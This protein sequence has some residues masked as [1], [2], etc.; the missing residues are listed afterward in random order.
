MKTFLVLAA[1]LALTGCNSVMKD[2]NA[3]EK[4]LDG[5]ISGGTIQPAILA[6][7]A[8]VDCCPVAG[9]GPNENHTGCVP[10]AFPAAAIK[11]GP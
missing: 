3:C 9:T 2:L 5:T 8:V 10:I 7:K 11:T 6:G 1:A 4:H